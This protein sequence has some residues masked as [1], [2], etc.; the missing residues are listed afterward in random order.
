MN[1][2]MG[3]SLKVA[4]IQTIS[5]GAVGPFSLTVRDCGSGG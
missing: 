4:A 1:G 2:C 3:R 5:L